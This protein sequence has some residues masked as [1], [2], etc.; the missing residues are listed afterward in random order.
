MNK[1]KLYPSVDQ[2]SKLYDTLKSLWQV[3]SGL[4]L[5]DINTIMLLITFYNI[6]RYSITKPYEKK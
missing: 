6:K 5:D 3:P 4:T 1:V 2:V